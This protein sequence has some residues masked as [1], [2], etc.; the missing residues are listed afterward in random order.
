MFRDPEN[1]LLPNWLHIPVGYH[2]RSSTIVPSG[3]PVHRPMGQTLPNG[4]QLQFL[5]HLKLDFELE[6]AFITT[7]ANI[8]GENIPVNETE[9]YIF[10][11]VLLNDWSA[12]DMQKWEY[13]P[14]GPFL[15]KNFASSI[16]PWIVTMDAL[17]PF[18]TKGPKQEPTP[19]PYL[20]QKGKHAYDI[21]L[22]VYIKPENVEET[23]VSK[24]NFKYMYWSMSQQLAHHTSNGCRVN[25]GDMMGS[26]T[27]SGPT[28]DS[29]G[30]MLELTWSGKNPIKMKDGS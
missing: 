16:S 21:N 15:A 23:L 8:M 29:Y 2:G 14:L 12:R 19:L 9:D 25:S 20:Q 30:S 26:G 5:V 6:M 27:I 4:Q 7:D 10:G 3:I 17:E 13:V 1:A 11:M 18:R 28:E 24:S 22:E